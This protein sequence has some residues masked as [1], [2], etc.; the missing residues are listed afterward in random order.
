MDASLQ[1]ET[2]T[3]FSRGALISAMFGAG[4]IGSGLGNAQAFNAFVAP[5]FGCTAFIL[6]AFSLHLMRRGRVLRK[7]C[8][9]T[10]AWNR[11]SVLTGFWLVVLMEVFAVACVAVLAKRFDRADLATDWCALIVGLHFLP[12]ARIF[13]APQLGV[14]G[15][16]VIF[17]CVASWAFLPSSAIALSAS[18]GTGLLLWGNCLLSLIRGRRIANE[19]VLKGADPV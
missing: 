2:V 15:I 14:L 3:G 12:L 10:G 1:S 9:M 16:L 18:L 19:V 5:V 6:I 8:L 13:R 17:W 4:W 7:M 11:Q